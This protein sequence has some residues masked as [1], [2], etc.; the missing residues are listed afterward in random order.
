MK[1]NKNDLFDV[2]NWVL[3]NT[4]KEPLQ[5]N[6][7]CFILNRWLSMSSVDNANI[8]NSTFN[9]WLLKKM[10]LPYVDFFRYILPTTKKKI[11][12]IKKENN[13][14]NINDLYHIS[15]NMELSMREIIFLE[16]SLADLN[17]GCN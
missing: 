11:Q 16:K 17:K 9:R 12:Y 14:D 4:K 8:V 2:L 10:I 5:K 15:N 3:K 13:L 6:V 1:K 7:S